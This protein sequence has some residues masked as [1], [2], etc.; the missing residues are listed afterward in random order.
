MREF[1]TAARVVQ[2]AKKNDGEQLPDVPFK[3]DGDEY[4]ARGPKGTQL[5]YLMAGAS[6]YKTDADRI[7]SLLDFFEEVLIEPGKARLR[8]RML[9]RDDPLDLDDVVPVFEHL[10]ETW[11]GRPNT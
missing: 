11:G 7:A 6:S 9:D 8:R 4:L 3:L 2:A 10:I 1:T 5:A